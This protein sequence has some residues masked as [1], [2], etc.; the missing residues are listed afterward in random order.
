MA[1]F[2]SSISPKFLGKYTTRANRS[3]NGHNSGQSGGY[4]GLFFSCH[5]SL[6]SK[7]IFEYAVTIRRHFLHLRPL[8]E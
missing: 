5:I 6:F 4:S 3:H 7:P 1:I 2:N 8:F